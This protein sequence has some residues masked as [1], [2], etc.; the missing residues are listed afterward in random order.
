MDRDTRLKLQGKPTQ[1]P[2]NLEQF[3]EETMHQVVHALQETFADAINKMAANA[4]DVAAAIEQVRDN[5]KK[6]FKEID[7]V[8]QKMSAHKICK[9]CNT[10]NDSHLAIGK[11]LSCKCGKFSGN[12]REGFRFKPNKDFAVSYPLAHF[13]IKE[14]G[15]S[16]VEK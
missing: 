13:E 1:E 6:T 8:Y 11:G 4:Q 9:E 3:R 10:T 5:A 14:C 7:E 16:N 15:D 12:D 2:V